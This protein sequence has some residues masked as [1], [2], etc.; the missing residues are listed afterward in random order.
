MRHPRFLA[1]ILKQIVALALSMFCLQQDAYPKDIT[2]DD[3][4][5]AATSTLNKFSPLNL[6]VN[7][8]IDNAID[9]G[10]SALKDRLDQVNG[11]IQSAILNL[12]QVL[13]ERVQ[14]LDQKARIQRMEAIRELDNLSV[15]IT[16]SLKA[17][18]DQLDQMLSQNITNFQNALANSLA[19][20]PIPTEPLINTSRSGLMVIANATGATRLYISG[21]GLFKDGR[22]P[23]A[24]IHEGAND[25]NGTRLSVEAASMGL[26]VLGIPSNLIPTTATPKIVTLSL[27]FYKG[28]FSK[29]VWPSFTLTVCGPLPRYVARAKMTASDGA[30][31]ERTTTPQT[32][33]YIDGGQVDIHAQ[34]LTPAGWSVDTDR[35][36]FHSGLEIVWN[37]PT[38]PGGS[39]E[40]SEQWLPGYS[41]YRLWVGGH[42]GNNSHA[43]AVAAIKKVTPTSTCG[44]AEDARTLGYSGVSQIQFSKAGVTGQCDVSLKTPNFLIVVE[45]LRQGQI[46]ETVNLPLPSYNRRAL[47]DQLSLSVDN[48]GLLNINLKPTC[49]EAFSY[50]LEKP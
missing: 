14:D 43:H 25:V 17:T 12:N 49:S 9:K 4:Y 50:S 29:T 37:P 10:N 22:Q 34:D 7:S 32:W 45:I 28:L 39:G 36:G 19:S 16:N 15:N 18:I 1:N 23:Q 40:H 41:A 13:K 31:W 11:I 30:Y 48:E 2:P 47:N 33:Y 8:L 5:S 42:G 46:I 35:A 3:I 6:T 38:S 44:T 20:L 24:W 26:L 21:S 27:G